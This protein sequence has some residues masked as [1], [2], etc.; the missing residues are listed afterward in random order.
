[1]AT[2][3]R[4]TVMS[5]CLHREGPKGTTKAE[6]RSEVGGGTKIINFEYG[7]CGACEYN[8]HKP[9]RYLPTL[10][11][12][13]A[14]SQDLALCASDEADV[15]LY[16]KELALQKWTEKMSE[17]IDIVG[18]DAVCINGQVLKLC[19]KRKIVDALIDRTIAWA[20]L[21]EQLFEC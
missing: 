6:R 11:R 18:P 15:P 13:W 9:F 7:W 10:H 19:L 5:I 16:L 1:M 12:N 20:L 2:T 8:V 14:E 4:L 3:Q 17:L 21:T